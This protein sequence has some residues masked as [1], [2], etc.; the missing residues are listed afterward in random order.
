MSH[1]AQ[2]ISAAVRMGLGLSELL[3]K[4]VKAEIF[5]R[6]PTIGGKTIEA[7][8]ASFN[9]GH[10]A[11]YPSRWLTLVGLDGAK[12]AAPANFSDLYAAGKECKDDPTGKIYPA[13]DVVKEAFFSSHRA[14]LELLPTIADSVFLAPNP[15]EKMRE[16]LPTVGATMIFYGASHMMM[17]LGQVSTWRRCFGLGSVM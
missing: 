12:I 1:F 16:R 6:K 17:H 10:L 5:A 3:L 8:H 13:M 11:L 7:N 2:D 15:N 9:F 4:D 14:A